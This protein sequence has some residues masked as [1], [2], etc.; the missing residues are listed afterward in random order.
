MIFIYPWQPD[1]GSTDSHL[2]GGAHIHFLDKMINQAKCVMDSIFYFSTIHDFQSGLIFINKAFHSAVTQ[3]HRN[4]KDNPLL[5]AWKDTWEDSD[6]NLGGF[7]YL[8][9]PAATTREVK[10]AKSERSRLCKRN[11][12]VMKMWSQTN[13]TC[14]SIVSLLI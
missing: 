5:P 1:I 13:R 12:K 2:T 8:C 10:V 7:K 9:D 6:G 3:N 4:Y 11:W 14:L